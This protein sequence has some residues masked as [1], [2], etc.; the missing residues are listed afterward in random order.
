MGAGPCRLCRVHRV[1]ELEAV[2]ST[3]SDAPRSAALFGLAGVAH[4]E[5]QRR[6]GT[7]PGRGDPK[8]P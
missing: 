5:A 6:R 8:L 2:H 4:M 3:L 1:A 7:E